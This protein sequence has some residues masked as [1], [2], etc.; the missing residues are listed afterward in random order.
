[1][2][3]EILAR[4]VGAMEKLDRLVRD[5]SP[6]ET[7]LRGLLEALIR[8]YDEKVELPKV[9]PYK[10]V[11][12]LMEQRGLSRMDLM[13]IFGSPSVTADVLNGKREL[14]D[15]HIRGLAEFFKLSPGAFF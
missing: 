9:E 1:M 12:Y 7:Q 3:P 6:E 2:R 13:P 14:S 15:A 5:L 4:F 11:L 8:E 10:V